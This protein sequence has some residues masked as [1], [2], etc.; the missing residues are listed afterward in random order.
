MN[1]LGGRFTMH[2]DVR[3]WEVIRKDP[4]DPASLIVGAYAKNSVPRPSRQRR[5]P[6]RLRGRRTPQP[7]IST[8]PWVTRHAHGMA[9]NERAAKEA[10]E[11]NIAS[12][13]RR[14]SE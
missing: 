1:Y 12:R 11:K 13:R 9:P 10:V 6:D 14:K 2:P 5:R 8:W 7:V 3:A 4:S